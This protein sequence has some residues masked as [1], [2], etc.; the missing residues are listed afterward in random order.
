MR[1]GRVS[2]AIAIVLLVLGVSLLA[3]GILSGLQILSEI[4]DLADILSAMS[5]YVGISPDEYG[6]AYFGALLSIIAIVVFAFR[7][8]KPYSMFLPFFLV[9]IYMTVGMFIRLTYNQFVPE[10]L[11][12]TLKNDVGK[13]TPLF[14]ILIIVEIALTSVLLIATSKL[15]GKWRRK[16][17]LIRK[18]L[19]SDGVL[20]SKEDMLAQKE[21]ARIDKDASL[22]EKKARKEAEKLEKDRAKAERKELRKASKARRKEDKSYE[23]SRESAE[24]K[25]ELIEDKEAAKARK[26]A[27]KQAYLESVEDDKRAAI[28][29]KEEKKRLKEQKKL[30]KEKKKQGEIIESSFEVPQGPPNPNNP[31]EFPDLPDITGLPEFE[32]KQRE[33]N[34]PAVNI[35]GRPSYE[36]PVYNDY[37][38]GETSRPGYIEKD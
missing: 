13:N 34:V 14:F 33:E 29:K 9:G 4:P 35:D 25:K 27:D 5:P 20:V 24:R 21:K 15:D 19:E 30:E 8:R 2:L 32:A 22:S 1:K 31:L 6:V 11:F 7:G 16:K 36:K 17:E 28:S 37:A 23:K 10:A 12:T 18:K 38:N 26:E 3:L